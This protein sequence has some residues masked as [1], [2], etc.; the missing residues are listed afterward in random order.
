MYHLL[1]SVIMFQSK[2]KFIIFFIIYFFACSVSI[3]AQNKDNHNSA[4][5]LGFGISKNNFTSNASYNY[6]W[7]IGKK[8]KWSVGTGARFTSSFSKNIYYTTA[9]A[10]LTTGKKGPGVF[11]G[12]DIPQ[13]I[14]SVFFKKVQTNA[15]NLTLN[16]HYKIVEKIEVGF[17]IDVIGFSFGAKQNAVYFG[18]NNI[19]NNTNAKPTSF[20]LLLISDNDL[21]SLNSEFFAKYNLNKSWGI[22]AAFQFLFTEY[23]TN[24]QVQTTPTGEKN[25]RFRNKSSQLSL[26]VTYKL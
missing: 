14:D 7:S 26:G 15:L 21:G 1:N 25:D 12:E 16:F 10:L 3:N 23:T 4:V 17:N 24:T 22:K 9:P 6:M 11:F 19:T 2:K 13:N 18:N 5:S 20:N 8:K